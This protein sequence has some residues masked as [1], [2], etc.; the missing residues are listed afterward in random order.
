MDAVPATD[1]TH[2]SFNPRPELILLGLLIEKECHGYALYKR[3]HQTFAGL[4]HISESQMY[5]ILKRLEEKKLLTAS[6]PGKRIAASRRILSPTSAGKTHFESWLAGPSPSRPRTLRLEFLTRL[7][8][9]SQLAPDSVPGLIEAQRSSVLESLRKIAGRPGKPGRHD[10]LKNQEPMLKNLDIDRL[11]DD[12]TIAQLRS[13][14]EWIDASVIP[15]IQE[16]TR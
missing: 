7:Y 13:A 15:A 10:C 3:F 5:A 1:Q 14:L 9:A 8:F 12:F 16:D 2:H 11:A 6:S 4:W